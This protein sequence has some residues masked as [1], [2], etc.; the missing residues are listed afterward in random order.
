MGLKD[1]LLGRRVALVSMLPPDEL[2]RRINEAT[3]SIFDMSTS[4]VGGWCR[5]GFLR[6]DW[7]MPFYTNGFAPIL[8]A[9]VRA[10]LG[11]TSIQGRFGASRYLQV[12]LAA[13]YGIL[14]LALLS[15][16]RAIMSSDLESGAHYLVFLIVPLLWFAPI[17]FHLIFN[18]KAD[19]NFEAILEFL[20]QEV[21]ARPE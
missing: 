2:A 8:S 4:G 12:F 9:K 19:R 21:S 14:T 5:F 11:R 18:R 7:R 15:L 6:L 10:N 20:A 3:P 16:P 1:Y 13:W 17:L